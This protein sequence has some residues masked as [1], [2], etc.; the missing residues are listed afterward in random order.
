MTDYLTRSNLR[1]ERLYFD[2][3]CKGIQSVMTGKVG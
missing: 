2:L 3:Q 1:E